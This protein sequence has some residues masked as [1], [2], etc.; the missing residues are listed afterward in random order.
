MKS[1]TFF[2]HNVYAM[3]GTVKSIS[4][5][6]NI[7]AEKG[8][9]VE[10]IT[11]FKG[12]DSPY[13]DIHESIKIKPLINYQF[14]P[15]NIKDI[16]INRIAKFTSFSRPKYI[17]QFEPGIDQFSHYIEK[18]MIKAISNVSTDVIVGTRASFNI[19]IAKYASTQIEKIGMEHM[20]FD[21]HSEP[22]QQEIIKS[23]KDLDKIT[24]LTTA[25]KN[26]YQ[27]HIDTPI[28]VVPNIINEVRLHEPKEKIICAAGR[29]EYEKGF[30]LLIE[31]I[32]P[33]QQAVRKF[34]YQVHIYGEGKEQANL[35]Q[36]INQY[37]IS[38]I[39]KLYGSTQ[40]L[41]EKLALSEITVIPSRN[42]GFG[43]VILEA[44]NQSSV[45]VS[46]DG[47]AGPDA[48]IQNNVN[49]YLIEH[50]NIDALSNQLRRLINQEF[51]DE[52]VIQNGYKTV[53]SYS[54]KAIYQ[55]FLT[56]LNA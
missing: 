35:Q 1:I 20:N 38:D 13:F 47:N 28:F 12:A 39:V 22:Y 43:M 25:D 27:S 17:S 44:M 48:I 8:H 5:M 9:H 51:K 3:G 23:Y 42:E 56:M 6:A 53:A 24:T 40:Q 29:L 36:L 33:I 34:N 11:I 52:V 31:S 49:G 54:P 46:F 45:V 2:M 4:Q 14:H 37:N 10:I 21:A 50:E 15:L 55:D 30:D 7:L 16:V 41:N 26:K 32:N 19:L 18:K